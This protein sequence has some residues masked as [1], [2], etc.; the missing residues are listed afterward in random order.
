MKNLKMVSN[1]AELKIGG[2]KI[3]VYYGGS[4]N[5]FI[6]EIGDIR[7]NYGHRNPVRVVEEILKRRHLAP[8]YGEMDIV[9]SKEGDDLVLKDLPDVFVVGG[10]HRTM[11]GSYNNILTISTS[12]FQS[13]TDF[14]IMVGNEPDP[15]KVPIL[16]LK[17]K[18]VKILDFSGGEVVWEEGDDLICKLDGGGR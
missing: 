8:V 18:E 11:I 10:Q 5:K 9:P 7:V 3:L 17:S 14:E 15:C 13:Q 2:L 16:N 4:L 6:D 1:P 12:C